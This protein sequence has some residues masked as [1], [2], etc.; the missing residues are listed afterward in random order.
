MPSKLVTESLVDAGPNATTLQL[1]QL[2]QALSDELE[3][4][5]D[6][7]IE[8]I[9]GSS[10]LEVFIA[11]EIANRTLE[12]MTV[13][14]TANGALGKNFQD[15]L[16]ASRTRLSGMDFQQEPLRLR[17]LCGGL[18]GAGHSSAGSTIEFMHQ[19]GKRFCQ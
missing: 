17:N 16:D 12:P 8:R 14:H 9:P 18:T 6:R 11:V 4:L 19:D 5:Y 1:G 15:C 2:L 10:R 7:T 3:E 13:V